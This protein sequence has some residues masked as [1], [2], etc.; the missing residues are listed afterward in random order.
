MP[1]VIEIQRNEH[2]KLDEERTKGM[3]DDLKGHLIAM[4]SYK[5][6]KCGCH[7]S[8]IIWSVKDGVVW[9]KHE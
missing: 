8:E 3:P 5:A 7:W 1:S 9:V 2:I 6:R 4:I